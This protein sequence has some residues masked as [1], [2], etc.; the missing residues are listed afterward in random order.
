MNYGYYVFALLAA[1]IIAMVI[2]YLAWKR[3]PSQGAAQLAFLMAAISVWTLFQAL[4]FIAND[5]ALKV[6]FANMR[7]FGIET[8]P[9]AFY[10]LAC[11]YRDKALGF[12]RNKWIKIFIIPLACTVLL[13]TNSLHHKFYLRV[14]LE[15]NILLL[16]N[17][18]VFWANMLYLYIFVAAGVYLFAV[19][20][21][22]SKSIYR[23]QSVIVAVAAFMPILA[24]L[25][26]NFD[27]LP[28]KD[29]DITPIAFL[30]TG[31]L[32]FF[33]LFQYKLLDVVPVA[34]DRLFEE[35]DDIVILLDGNKRILDL[36]KK[37]REIIFG[38]NEANRHFIGRNILTFLDD[39][40]QLAD[41][42]ADP[43]NPNKRIIH[44]SPAGTEY[45]HL[46]MS[47]FNYRKDDKS[48]ELIVLRNITELEEA[49]LEAK[50]ARE[51]A[52]NANKA[53]GYFLAN[54][55]HEI[56]TP[57]NAV[58]GIAEILN[59][60]DMP[61]DK[62]KD[63]IG[64]ILNSAQSLL[65][66][67]NDI[68]DFSKIDAGKMEIEKSPFDLRKL[69]EE[70]V[71]TFLVPAAN[72]SLKLTLTV[73]ERLNGGLNG[74][75]VR[76]KQILTNLIGNSIKFTQ[77][78][79]VNVAVEQAGNEDNRVTVN[80]I[81]SDS[82]IGIPEEKLDSIFE[83][84]KQGDSTTTRKYGGTGLG[85]SIVK[86]L[87]E[88]MGGSIRVESEPGKGSRFCCT[89]P[90][91]RANGKLDI[92]NGAEYE[93]DN[94]G[95]LPGLK[96]LVAEDNRIN[97]EIMSIHLGKL[98]CEYDF[99]ENGVIACEKF[100]QN[101]YDLILMD[102]QMP[103]MDGLEATRKIRAREADTGGRIKIIALTAGAMKDDIDKCIDAGMDGHISKPVK[104]QVLYNFL[105]ECKRE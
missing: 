49:L 67:I 4:T 16:K 86:S 50:N 1:S 14:A 76:V 58:I 80:I 60:S 17:G 29:I 90:F 95:S 11:G 64:M 41:S 94:Q 33:A 91:E 83:S 81:V 103:E 40:K 15:G 68:L 97:R 100:E 56:R 30:I 45:Y 57:M 87:A 61:R 25:A 46:R 71:N 98:G 37:A 31:V 96:I 59:T 8:V 92:V 28:F 74:D 75:Y 52:E 70:T 82:G 69:A 63:Y 88:L 36:N 24:N 79:Y 21:I 43:S 39:W 27:L 85:L 42:I 55:S 38:G 20:C 73:D 48:G 66:I 78:G 104:A 7:Y 89:L 72:K 84:F 102:V 35:M 18:P 44:N 32:F 5:F 12:D 53:K 51:E 22:N 77:E 34:M 3:R 101:D 62:Q 13:W 26:F 105:K 93:N 65:T 6:I 99:A 10:A 47:N 19:A 54:M 9:I 2:C 23:G